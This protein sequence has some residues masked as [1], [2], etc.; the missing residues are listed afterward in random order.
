MNDEKA[1]IRS[2]LEE[3][4]L[5]FLISPLHPQLSTIPRDADRFHTYFI[6][7]KMWNISFNGIHTKLF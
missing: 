2:P 1:G 4:I 6:G 5:P 7:V 3:R